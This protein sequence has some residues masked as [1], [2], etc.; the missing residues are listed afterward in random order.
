MINESAGHVRAVFFPRERVSF[1]CPRD[2]F[3]FLGPRELDCFD[4]WHVTHSHPIWK[5]FWVCNHNKLAHPYNTY[6]NT[7][8]TFKILPMSFKRS[9]CSCDIHRWL[10]I[11][12]PLINDTNTI[13]AVPRL[14][15]VFWVKPK[16]HQ[17]PCNS[18]QDTMHII[19]TNT[20]AY[21]IVF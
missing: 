11:T 6:L 2:L 18:Q 12:K 20:F 1:A 15:L 19:Q 14:I 17:L 7:Y 8:F 13:P 10:D 9:W 3:M 4:T 5:L 21:V 16:G